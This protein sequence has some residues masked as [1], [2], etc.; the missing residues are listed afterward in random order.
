MPFSGPY[1][2][3]KFPSSKSTD[4]LVE[5]FRTSAKRFIAALQAAQASVVVDDTYR[6][7]ER[8]YLM[9]FAW[10]IAR[11]NFSPAN[12]KAQAGVDIQWVH[13][14]PLG[15]PDLAASK[16][17]AEQMVQG[18]AIAF[19]PVLATRHTER[20]AVDMTI[21]WQ[22]DLTI[23]AG[24]GSLTT[25]TSLPRTGA[26]NTDLHAVGA[27]YGVIKLVKDHPHWSSDGH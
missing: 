1:W 10:E 27:T 26:G 21:T 20:L 13:L 3:S 19:E 16:A 14:D 24:D 7:V 25:I 12:V 6:P 11:N 15:Q 2:V 8:A 4:D 5:P 22:G 18:Y 23:A 9:R 17:A